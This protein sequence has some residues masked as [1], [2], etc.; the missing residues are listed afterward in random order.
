EASACAGP[1]CA[2][3]VWSDGEAALQGDDRTHLPVAYDR[4]GEFVFD[5]DALSFADRQIPQAGGDKAMAGVK[6]R[7]A[8]FALEAI[9]VQR[10]QRVVALHTDA[11]GHIQRLGVGIRRQ[12]REALA[13]ALG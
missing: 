3:D 13:V 6:G 10:E 4:I 11:T 7:E 9:A 8:I 12:Q 5:V 1:V 2:A